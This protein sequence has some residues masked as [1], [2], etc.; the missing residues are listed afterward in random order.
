MRVCFPRYI[1]GC[2]AFLNF[3]QELLYGLF[4]HLLA[5]FGPVDDQGHGFAGYFFLHL[6]P[7]SL[8]VPV[9]V[10]LYQGRII[11]ADGGRS[12]IQGRQQIFLD[13]ADI[14][15]VVPHTVHDI[16]VHENCPAS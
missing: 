3:L 4:K 12:V 7:P 9:H 14:G 15:G 1:F 6:T 10:V 16:L 13:V 2:L 5:H 8:T 11:I